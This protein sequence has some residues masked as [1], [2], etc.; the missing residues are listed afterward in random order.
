MKSTILQF[1]QFSVVGQV[2]FA[3]DVVVLWLLAD[4]IPLIWARVLA[5]ALAVLTN[6]LCH[7]L[8]TF[9]EHA[10]LDA[11]LKEA[12]QFAFASILGLLPNIGLYWW[13]IRSD[14]Y[15]QYAHL[16]LAPVLAMIPGIFVGHCLN[17][18]LSK[19]WVFKRKADDVVDYP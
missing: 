6:W 8:Y 5:F 10:T 1:F 17:F 4:A 2:S 19:Y 16:S 12:T 11:K 9:K 13:A 14:F 3:V 7:R 15:E 18:L